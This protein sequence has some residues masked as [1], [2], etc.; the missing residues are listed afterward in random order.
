MVPVNFPQLKLPDII[1]I[2]ILTK[3]AISKDYIIMS[4]NVFSWVCEKLPEVREL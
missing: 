2:K 3:K 4:S 1:V